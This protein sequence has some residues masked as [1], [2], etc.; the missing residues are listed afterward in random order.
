MSQPAVQATSSKDKEEQKRQDA[1]KIRD[2]AMKTWG[3]NKVVPDEEI[4]ED[5]NKVE[6]PTKRRRKGSD[7]LQY[8]AV[9]TEKETELK[10]QETEIRKQELELRREELR[11][12][13]D[14]Q[15][16]QL[17]MQMEQMK[18]M[19]EVLGKLAK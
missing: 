15:K 3:K 5:D 7:A 12:Q 11:L 6:I 2:K 17:K 4:D 9:K 8:L 19:A 16:E 14:Y 10:L 13:A 18:F 1:L